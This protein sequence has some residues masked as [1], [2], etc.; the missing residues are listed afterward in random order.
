MGTAEV[1]KMPQNAAKIGLQQLRPVT[2]ELRL[3]WTF[4]I[5]DASSRCVE[6]S[7]SSSSMLSPSLIIRGSE[8]KLHRHRRCSDQAEKTRNAPHN[9]TPPSSMPQLHNKRPDRSRRGHP[10]L[11]RQLDEEVPTKRRLVQVEVRSEEIRIEEEARSPSP[12][13]ENPC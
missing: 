12:Y 10:N 13:S 9:R 11:H 1:R 3:K 6:P 4:S 7:H 5:I 8:P 2:L